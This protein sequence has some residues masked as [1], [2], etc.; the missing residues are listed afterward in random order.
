[1]EGAVASTFSLYFVDMQKVINQST[2][3]KQARNILESK[4]ATYRQKIENMNT[5]IQKIK[6]ELS[7]PILSQK[8]KT[9]D[10]NKLQEKIAD[11]QKFEQDAKIDISNLERQYTQEIVVDVLKIV[12]RYRKQNK[13][14]MIVE[15]NE[16]GI[17]SADPRYDLTDTIIKIYNKQVK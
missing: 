15:K 10:E 9:E 11:L 6:Q 8:S 3:G 14:P 13:I 17:L 7:N 2:K 4:V 16:A 5:E 12:D 1:I